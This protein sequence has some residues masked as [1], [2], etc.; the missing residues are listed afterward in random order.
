MDTTIRISKATKAELAKLGAKDESYESIVK[1]LLILENNRKN[2]SRYDA[3][4]WAKKEHEA[5]QLVPVEIHVP[6]N[7]DVIQLDK[8]QLIDAFITACDNT[9]VEV[10]NLNLP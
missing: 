2:H 4:L 7:I 10:K 9:Y 5:P 3:H 6:R 1:R 8:R